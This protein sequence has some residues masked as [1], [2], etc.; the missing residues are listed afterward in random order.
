MATVTPIRRPSGE[1]PALH[2]RAMDNL[3]FIRETMDSAAVFTAVSG[4]GMVA[5]GG[6]AAITTPVAWLQPTPARWLACWMVAAAAS[7]LVSG[8]ASARKAHRADVPLLSGP[9]RKF[10]LSFA[11]AMFAGAVLTVALFVFGVPQLLPGMWLLVYGAAVVAAGTFSV[12]IVPVMGLCFMVLG[13]IAIALPATRDWLMLAG[14]GGVHTV[15]GI[16]IA[17]RHGG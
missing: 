4:W 3:R 7:I 16:F 5:V 17:R 6:L 13:A 8:A 2:A 11:P 14:F 12:R 9:G 10:L 1:A 15:F